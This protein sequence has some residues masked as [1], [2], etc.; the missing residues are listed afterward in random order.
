M[1]QMTFLYIYAYIYIYIYIREISNNHV[2]IKVLY[3]L[4][5][6]EKPHMIGF[7]IP[8]HINIYSGTSLDS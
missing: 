7:H 1:L 6:A 3:K 5:E 4:L 8:E 2:S